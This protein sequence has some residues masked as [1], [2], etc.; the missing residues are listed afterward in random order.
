MREVFEEF[1][2]LLLKYFWPS[3]C[4]TVDETLRAF[5]GRCSFVTYIPNKPAK[6][7]LLIRD[8]SDARSRYMLRM[9]PYAGKAEEPDPA[10]HV[11]GASNIVKH[12]V[13]P[14]KNSRR[15]VTAD[16]FFTGVKLCEELL[17]D[18]LTYVGT[19]MPSR[20]HLPEDAKRTEE[21]E[22]KSTIFYWPED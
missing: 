11:T 7:G 4:V 21:R 16:H 12:L 1:N 13:A 22:E 14:L 2:A 17:E 19:V 15:I 8:M 9:L 20:R 3:D 18:R 10:F 5:R 6:Y